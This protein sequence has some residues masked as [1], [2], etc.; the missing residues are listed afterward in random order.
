MASVIESRTEIR[1][2]EY[3]KGKMVK[4]NKS[5]EDRQK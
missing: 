2:S 5:G 1:T 4:K 3:S